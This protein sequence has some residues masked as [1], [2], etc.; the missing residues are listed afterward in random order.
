MSTQII[1]SGHQPNFLPY[2]GYFYKMFRSDVFVLDDDVQFSSKEYTNKNYIRVNGERYR[3][4]IPVSY[5]FGDL[6]NKVKISYATDWAVKLI[7]TIEMNYG[8]AKHYEEGFEFISRH[9]CRK[10]ELLCDLNTYMIKEIAGR[11]DIQTNI[12]IASQR[13]GNTG[14][15]RNARNIYQCEQLGGTVYY[16]GIGGKSYNDEI[17]YAKKGIRIQYSDYTPVQYKQVG[18]KPF[19]ENLSVLDYIMNCGFELPEE[20]KKS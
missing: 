2:M 12:I 8:K 5:E 3:I 13:F 6:I 20:W 1:F 7:K 14:L 17:S 10:Y 18:R 11:F 4:T 15:V 19:L 9:L 16:S